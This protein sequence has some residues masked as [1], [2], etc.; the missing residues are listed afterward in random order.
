MTD[1]NGDSSSRKMRVRLWW[2]DLTNYN[3]KLYGTGESEIPSPLVDPGGVIIIGAIERGSNK[4][5]IW[6][7]PRALLR[8]PRA[9]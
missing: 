3:D 6:I 7:I 1:N 2:Y 5:A 4:F 8:K 9:S